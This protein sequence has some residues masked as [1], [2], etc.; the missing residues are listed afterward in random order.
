MLQ[1]TD[2]FAELSDLQTIYGS[3]HY[4]AVF[5]AGQI[6]N[7]TT[8]LM[9]MNPTARNISSHKTWS[10]IRAPWIG[11]KQVW[12]MLYNLG[13][14]KNRSLLSQIKKMQSAEWTT[15]FAENLYRELA[16]E[17]IYITNIAK[18]TQDDARAL[19]NTVYKAYL[20]VTRRELKIL[21]PR[22]VFCFGNQVSSVLLGKSISVS[23]YTTNEYEKLELD[24]DT[25]NI[26]PTYYP[27]GQGMRNMPK[28]V[29]RITKVLNAQV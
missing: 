16:E 23:R 3:S 2:L 27:V 7:P 10:G 8:C 6:S 28:A 11:T 14:F 21:K 19:P 1:I 26:Y 5:G 20:S 15:E 22:Y 25:I 9:F 29:D 24:T 17:S 12:S 13:L 18:C 4:E